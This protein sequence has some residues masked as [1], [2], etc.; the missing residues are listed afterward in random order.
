MDTALPPGRQI[1]IA[2]TVA[3]AFVMQGIDTTLLTIAIPTIA[4]DLGVSPLVMHF[5]ITAYLLSL[6]VF[7]PVSG[8]FADRFGPRRVFSWAVV[9]FV[10]GSAL[11][12]LSPNIGLMVPARFLQGFGGALMTP[13]G[14]LILL[15]AFGKG[16]SLDAMMWL[17]IPV[18]IG[19]LVGPLLGAVIVTN[20]DWRWIF[21]VNVPVCILTLVLARWLIPPDTGAR[22]KVGFDWAGFALAGIALTL[23]QLAVE[24]LGHPLVG[25]EITT[26]ALLAAALAVFWIYRRHASRHAAPALDL[27]L[28]RIPAFRTGVVAGGIGRVGLNALPFL[29]PLVFQIGLGMSPIEAGLLSSTAAVG[30]FCA[31]PFLKRMVARWGYGPTIAGMGALG[32]ALIAG[33]ALLHPGLSAWVVVPYIVAAGAIRMVFFNSVNGLTYS[34]VPAEELSR[35]VATAGVFQQLSMGLGI[36]LSAALLALMSGEGH[37]VEMSDFAAVFLMMAV[38]PLISVPLFARLRRPGAVPAPS[39]PQSANARV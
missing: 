10:L 13:V 38:I 1:A 31:K 36:S 4:P 29:L 17:T 5:A 37:V 8:W 3:C 28:F 24:H 2:G 15:R 23:F 20:L 14:R 35:S 7:M 32:S 19:P 27:A 12:G 33:F 39:A 6:A 26:L 9:I 30:A 22:L 25:G 21:F 18:L 11:S 16:R 34:E